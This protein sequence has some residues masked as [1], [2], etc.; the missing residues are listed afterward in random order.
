[1]PKDIK[2][3]PSTGQEPADYWREHWTA[4]MNVCKYNT[5]EDPQRLTF[6]LAE[7]AEKSNLTYHWL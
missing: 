2:Y 1:M 7:I 4:C 3:W 5:E 6:K